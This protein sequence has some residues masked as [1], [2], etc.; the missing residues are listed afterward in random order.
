MP[1][2]KLLVF[3]EDPMLGNLIGEVAEKTGFEAK[4]VTDRAHFETLYQPD[5]DVLIIDLKVLGSLG[6]GYWLQRVRQPQH[7][8]LLLMS[9]W[10]EQE[11]QRYAE[12]AQD[13]GLPVIGTLSKPFTTGEL[14]RLFQ[15]TWLAL[16]TAGT[17]VVQRVTK[18]ELHQGLIAEELVAY[19]QPKVNPHSGD[20]IGVEALARWS[21]P[22]KGLV[23]PGLFVPLAEEAGLITALFRAIA[24]QTFAQ[25]GVWEK[26]GLRLKTAINISIFDLNEPDLPETLSDLAAQYGVEPAQIVLE[27]TES[28]LLADTVTPLEVLA[29]LA[30]QGVE[31]SIDDFGTGYATIQQLQRIPF[32]ELKI[33]RF[34]VHEAV[35]S[36]DSL[37]ILESMFA[38]ARKLGMR[39]VAE[40]VE[41]EQHWDLLSHLGCDQVQGY[42]IGR[43]MPGAALP[44]W[45]AHWREQRGELMAHAKNPARAGPTAGVSQAGPENSILQGWFLEGVFDDSGLLQ[46]LPINQIP[47]RIG[48]QPGLNLRIASAEISR[49]HAEIFRR[50]N[51]L[52]IRDLGSTNGTFV[53]HER[54]AQEA[55]LTAGDQLAFAQ[56]QCRLLHDPYGEN[57]PSEQLTSALFTTAPAPRKPSS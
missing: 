5:I 10:P 44:A 19:F 56:T 52:V 33:D 24:N 38:M 30:R 43:P 3:D 11:L 47:F 27:I 57:R 6:I 55:R 17:G 9:D 23:M 32:S 12:S 48:R 50:G 8:V 45:L 4:I 29:R 13:Q 31:L 2:L 7:A 46:R 41:T 39:V 21:H 54:V 26:Q 40:G 28:G 15:D 49:E 37:V 14:T 35:K 1:T 22:T 34:F 16:P 25:C 20:L 51:H 18:E 36:H 53:N 42:L